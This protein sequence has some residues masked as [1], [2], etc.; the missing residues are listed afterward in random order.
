MLKGQ[1]EGPPRVICHNGKRLKATGQVASATAPEGEE[2]AAFEKFRKFKRVQQQQQ[3]RHQQQQQERGEECARITAEFDR[4]NINSPSINA[5][6]EVG[7]CNNVNACNPTPPL[8]KHLKPVGKPIFRIKVLADTGAMQSLISL[9]TATKHGCKIRE[10]D[11]RLSAANGTKI[12]VAGT[13]SLQVVEKGHLAH[14]IVAIVSPNVTQTIVGWQDLRAMG[15][16]SSEW[17]AMPP[18]SPTTRDTICAVEEEER[19]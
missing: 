5:I 6:Q 11:V 2:R 1:E 17:P 18:P 3:Q 4:W 7:K 19:Q 13:T 10:T 12:D 14:T 9:S 8:Y 15:V 16:I